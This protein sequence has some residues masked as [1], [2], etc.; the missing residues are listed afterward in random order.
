VRRFRIGSSCSVPAVIAR[1]NFGLSTTAGGVKAGGDGVGITGATA[2]CDVTFVAGE[3]KSR[4]SAITDYEPVTSMAGG[5]AE[6]PANSESQSCELEAAAVLPVAVCV[7]MLAS[8]RGA[9]GD[10]LPKL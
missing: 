2:A 5:G 3:L 10:E 4:D 7:C 1:P 6:I 9:D 8:A